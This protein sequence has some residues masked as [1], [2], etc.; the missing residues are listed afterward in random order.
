MG[1]QERYPLISSFSILRPRASLWI[2]VHVPALCG[3][4]E[5]GCEIFLSKFRKVIYSNSIPG[6]NMLFIS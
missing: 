4:V 3:L 2:W 6:I 5:R 1:E